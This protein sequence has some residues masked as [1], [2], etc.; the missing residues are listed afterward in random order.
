MPARKRGMIDARGSSARAWETPARPRRQAWYLVY[1]AVQPGPTH[2]GAARNVWWDDLIPGTGDFWHPIT[3][4][5]DSGSHLVRPFLFARPLFFCPSPLCTMY[6]YLY[7][8][9]EL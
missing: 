1:V 8:P 6:I 4:R 3:V 5:R 2:R 7:V 9:A